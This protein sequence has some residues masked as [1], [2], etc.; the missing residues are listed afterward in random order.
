LLKAARTE[1]DRAIVGLL[2]GAGLRVAQVSALDVADLIYVAGGPAVYVRRGKGRRDPSL[3]AEDIESTRRF[4][5]AGEIVGI[6]LLDGL[7]IGHE[8][9]VS[10]QERGLL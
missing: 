10:M 7:V 9:A 5:R 4:K 2:L 3:S 8:S 6:P 1:R